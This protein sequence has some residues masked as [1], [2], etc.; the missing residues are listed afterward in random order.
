[1]PQE[2]D[3]VHDPVS[4]QEAL[5]QRVAYRHD[6]GK[7]V[8]DVLSISFHLGNWVKREL[9]GVNN[10][11]LIKFRAQ[12]ECF[13]LLPSEMLCRTKVVLTAA[14]WVL[15]QTNCL[16]NPK[17]RVPHVLLINKQTA[18]PCVSEEVPSV[19]GVDGLCTAGCAL[20]YAC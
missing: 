14:L 19:C 5:P 6:V 15:L 2:L 20:S 18:W 11:L 3:T 4:L 1:M 12:Y 7:E 17:D 10:Q 9:L 16:L 13:E 8:I